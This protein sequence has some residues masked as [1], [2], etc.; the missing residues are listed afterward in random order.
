MKPHLSIV[1]IFILFLSSQL[2]AGNDG[3]K[4][5]SRLS[6]YT[7]EPTGHVLVLV[8]DAYR[9]QSVTIDLLHYGRP[10][11]SG[12]LL[13]EDTKAEIV[14]F[15]L[16]D[17]REGRDTLLCIFYVKEKPVDSTDVEVCKLPWKSNEVKID[18]F[19]GGLL[20]DGMPFFP[21]GFYCRTPVSPTLPEEEV[22]KGFNMISPYQLIELKTIRERKAYMDRCAG[23]GMKVNYQLISVAGG[24]GVNEAQDKKTSAEDKMQ[25]LKDEVVA[26]RDHPALLAWYIAD[27]PDG[28]GVPPETL[29]D[30]YRTIKELDPYHPVTIVLM[31]PSRAMEYKDVLDIVMAD[32]YP[33]PNSPVTEVSD[34]TE[35]L[36]RAF[37]PEKPVWIV[38]QAFGGAE[39]W[40]REPTQREIRSMT[41]LAIVNHATGIQ[42]FIRHGLNRFPKSQAMWAECGAMALEVAD[43]TPYFF[44]A[45][46]FASLAAS[47]EDVQTGAWVCKGETLIIAVNTNPAPVSFEIKLDKAAISGEA[48]V[49]YENRKV[50]LGKGVLRDI[51]DG[52]GTRIYK[53]TAE[54]LSDPGEG[55][56]PMNLTV[57]P[58]FEESQEPGIPMACYAGRGG[59]R[60]ATYFTDTRT[61]YQGYRSLK[62]VTPEESHG[63]K[64]SFYPVQLRTGQTY[65]CSVR[66][67]AGK[68]IRLEEKE[69]FFKKL[70]LKKK[71]PSDY[72]QFR[73]SLGDDSRVFN[74]DGEWRYYSF[75]IPAVSEWKLVHLNP[76][77]ELLS[78]GTAWFDLLQ[79]LPDIIIQSR[80]KTGEEGLLVG[81]STTREAGEVR[82]TLDETVPDTLSALYEGPF[83][84]RESCIL[85]AAIFNEGK[86]DGYA[87]EELLVHKGTGMSLTYASPYSTLYTG[88]GDQ[89]LLDGKRGTTHYKDGLWQGFLKKDM[90]VV[91]NLGDVIPVNKVTAGFLQDQGVWIFLPTEVTFSLSLHGTDEVGTRTV[92][93]KNA[94]SP[95][96]KLIKDYSATFDGGRAQF[97]RIKAKSPGL[98]PAWHKGSGK[99]AWIF[100]DEVILE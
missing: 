13:Q 73:M 74:L 45:T 6:Y 7:V 70:S 50:A 49:L 36:Y 42:Y 33:V 30:A 91:I 80:T 64:L 72:M 19:S 32:P 34:W 85:K 12:Y 94:I 41:Y 88:G 71:R 84:I 78:R 96:S 4:A 22:V 95:G 53:L 9:S 98:C 90:E 87:E 20:V 44:G 76:G 57:D 65:S 5:I 48:D 17:F 56:H 23:L 63:V 18:H 99:P 46:R 86:Q 67:K 8:P 26:F 47:T 79:V 3:F 21:Y 38:P 92:S 93:N 40:K 11:V 61:F 37:Y 25:M 62:L 55:I 15:R 35:A 100:C 39:W 52:F 1:V 69:S 16:Q 29:M 77:L 14:P 54:P 66:A 10:L 31:T 83:M 28:Q 82:Y 43:L 24:G 89:A 60:G 2:S 59:D 58:G 27:E 81:L 68:Q 97:I 75:V 51:I